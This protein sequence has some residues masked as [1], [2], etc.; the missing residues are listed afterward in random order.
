MAK[1]GPPIC[2]REVSWPPWPPHGYSHASTMLFPLFHQSS[3]F[4]CFL[5]PISCTLLVWVLF[6]WVSFT[7]SCECGCIYSVRLLPCGWIVSKV[8]PGYTFTPSQQ[9]SHSLCR[10][11]DCHG[12]EGLLLLVIQ[13]ICRKGMW[14][15]S[16]QACC[17]WEALHT[18]YSLGKYM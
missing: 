9:P 4:F 5:I 10:S 13:G 17:L 3:L 14:H 1:S 15:L 18:H 2:K 7:H 11:F 8:Q 12:Q 16:V 6:Y